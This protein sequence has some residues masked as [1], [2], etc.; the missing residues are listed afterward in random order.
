MAIFDGELSGAS[1]TAGGPCGAKCLRL[2]GT[3]KDVDGRNAAGKPQNA[4]PWK[5]GEPTLEEVLTEPIVHRV[6]AADGVRLN[7]LRNI[8]ARQQKALENTTVE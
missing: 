7:D 3:V 1:R 6:M 8:I 5:F 2:G 4:E